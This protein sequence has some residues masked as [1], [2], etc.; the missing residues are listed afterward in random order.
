[1]SLDKIPVQIKEISTLMKNLMKIFKIEM[2]NHPDQI[3]VFLSNLFSFLVNS[4]YL[5]LIFGPN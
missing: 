2:F 4:N 1:M 3:N 5:C